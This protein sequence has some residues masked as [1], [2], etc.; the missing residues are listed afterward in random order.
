MGL[1]KGWR[2]MACWEG[3][4]ERRSCFECDV[5]R[6]NAREKPSYRE[7]FMERSSWLL[8]RN[9]SFP[10][11]W[12]PRPRCTH[13]VNNSTISC[14]LCFSF[15]FY[16]IFFPFFFFLRSRMRIEF[17]SFPFFF[18][19]YVSFAL[20]FNIWKLLQYTRK[21][22]DDWYDAM[23]FVKSIDTFLGYNVKDTIYINN[24]GD[25]RVK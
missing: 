7:T 1:V 4:K 21:W 18:F 23:L 19:E 22:I 8:Q 15:L 17:S 24:L 14:I 25:S 16:F 10:T 3:E 13:C 5:A 9:A 20:N 6:S 12:I 11:T 2:K